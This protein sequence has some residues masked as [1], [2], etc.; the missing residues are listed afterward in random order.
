[1]A[2]KQPIRGRHR[3]EQ[4]L[5][6]IMR[7]HT[8]RV[9][10]EL[11]HLLRYSKEFLKVS[12]SPISIDFVPY[13]QQSRPNARQNERIYQFDFWTYNNLPLWSKNELE[14]GA[15]EFYAIAAI[16]VKSLRKN[17]TLLS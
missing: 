9:S 8:K 4:L 6:I 10:D 3:N 11:L 13:R 1:M 12:Q 16:A 2:T 17:R 15:I 14:I 7:I 5:N